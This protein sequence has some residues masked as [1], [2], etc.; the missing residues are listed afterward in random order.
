MEAFGF[1][2]RTAGNG[3]EGLAAVAA[4]VPSAIITDLHMPEMDG[5]ELMNALR[6]TWSGIP[7]VAISGGVTKGF[8]FLTAA[9]HMGAAATFPK[10]LAVLEVVDAIH[11]LTT[12][13][14]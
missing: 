1:R 2:T 8:D 6:A 9:K 5:F 4:E 11:G 12:K 14:A 13:A 3:F 7:I 10:P